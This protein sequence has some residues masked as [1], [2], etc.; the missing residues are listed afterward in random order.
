MG[1]G[2][3][4]CLQWLLLIW[5]GGMLGDSEPLGRAVELLLFTVCETWHTCMGYLVHSVGG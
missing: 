4:H 1:F 5:G 2:L 3:S